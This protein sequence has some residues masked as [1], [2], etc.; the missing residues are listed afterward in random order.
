VSEADHSPTTN[1]KVKKMW[2]ST[3]LPHMTSWHSGQLVKYS[4]ITFFLPYCGQN[5]LFGGGGVMAAKDLANKLVRELSSLV[6]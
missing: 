2:I 1:A 6:L 3:S 4:D 5:M